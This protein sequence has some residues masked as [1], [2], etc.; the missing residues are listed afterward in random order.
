[1]ALEGSRIFALE[2]KWK[3]MNHENLKAFK[4]FVNPN[5]NQILVYAHEICLIRRQERGNEVV[6][7]VF[8]PR[9][10]PNYTLAISAAKICN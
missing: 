8:L 4:N 9:V 3:S 2:Q 6:F 5:Y 1:M 10:L 7:P